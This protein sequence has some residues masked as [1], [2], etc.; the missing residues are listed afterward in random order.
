MPQFSAQA[1]PNADRHN[2]DANRPKLQYS[3][4]D[5]AFASYIIEEVRGN[6]RLPL[7]IAPDDVFYAV[8]HFTKWFYEMYPDATEDDQ[9]IFDLALIPQM[10]AAL[11]QASNFKLRT[12][13]LL[14]P[15]CVYAISNVFYINESDFASTSAISLAQ[16]KLES[17][18]V[19]SYATVGEVYGI[20]TYLAG[21][22][23]SNVLQ[24]IG[25]EPVVFDFNKMTHIMKFRDNGYR[26]G[27][28]ICDVTR[29]LQPSVLYNDQWYQNFIVAKVLE[30]KAKQLNFADATTP[31][32]TKIN[33]NVITDKAKELM[34]ELREQIT[35]LNDTDFIIY[36]T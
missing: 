26:Q 10:N 25:K 7:N 8:R 33:V 35:A 20:D 34:D 14:L 27:K 29:C 21:I 2:P 5:Y 11:D 9:L 18:L 22:F 23:C 28:I 6:H 12:N 3:N 1:Q 31:G 36:K 4:E 16:W 32:D 15:S 13:E 30:E 24:S 19:N 17:I